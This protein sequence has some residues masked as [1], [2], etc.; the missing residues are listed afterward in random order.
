LAFRSRIESKEV[1]MIDREGPSKTEISRRAYALYLLRGCGDGRDVEDWVR[2]EKELS[3]EY[4]AGTAKTKT[5][6][7]GR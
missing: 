2:A 1:A 5:A 7:A 6:Q 3:D 4:V